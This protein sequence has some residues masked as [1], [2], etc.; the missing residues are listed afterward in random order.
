MSENDWAHL[1]PPPEVAGFSLAGS[2]PYTISA[3]ENRALCL[4]TGVE[5]AADGTA[6][7]VYFYIATQIGMGSTVAGLCA[8][9]DF[10]VEQGPMMAS[11]QVDFARPLVTGQPY[12]VDGRILSLVR[13]NS[14]KLGVMD[15]MEYQL[16]LSLPDGTPVL[17]TTNR[18]V[19]PRGNAQ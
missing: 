6:H 19:L 11:S 18:W 1:A 15:L 9:C 7:P 2:E 14:R 12:R 16:E 13:K 5:P 4:S 10:D 8:A 3:E 17:R